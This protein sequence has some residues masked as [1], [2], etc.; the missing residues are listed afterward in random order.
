MDRQTC[1]GAF[2]T[3]M[4]NNYL[5]LIICYHHLCLDCLVQQRD[6]LE[7]TIVVTYTRILCA[8]FFYDLDGTLTGVYVA[9]TYT[10]GGTVKGASLV[11]RSHLLPP[12]QCV[13]TNMSTQGVGG[14]VCVGLIF[15]RFFFKIKTPSAWF[16]RALCVRPPWMSEIPPCKVRPCHVIC[17]GSLCF[18]M[19]NKDYSLSLSAASVSHRVCG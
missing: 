12:D 2:D 7:Y 18:T 4:S 19:C 1:T 9:E 10:K 8:A 17:D 3:N 14:A 11:P 5:E 16:G 15:K 6:M 13:F